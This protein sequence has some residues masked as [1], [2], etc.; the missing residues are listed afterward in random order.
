[1]TEGN[2]DPRPANREGEGA[3]AAPSEK[4]AGYAS[5][6]PYA[7]RLQ[8]R[9]DEIIDRK[10]PNSGTFCGLCFARLATGAERCPY[11]N[12][13]TATRATADKVPREVLLAYRAK[14]R[15]EATWVYSGAFVGLMIAAVLFVVMVVWA[16]GLLGHPGVAF[17]VLIGGGYVLAQIFGPLIGGQ[18]GY[19]VGSRKRDRLWGRLLDAQDASEDR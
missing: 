19:R 5:P 7:P 18:L 6:Y 13:E 2:G 3:T 8:D 16:P 4:V 17:L 14:K 12:T 11:C 15:T 9:M 1:M 10:V